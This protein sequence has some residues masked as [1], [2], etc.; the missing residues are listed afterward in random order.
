MRSSFGAIPRSAANITVRLWS[1]T[2]SAVTTPTADSAP[3]DDGRK[4][5]GMRSACASA[6]ACRPPAPPKGTSVKSRGSFPFSTETWR[7]AR[8]IFVLTTSSTPSAA[9][10]ALIFL[11]AAVLI[12][13]ASWVNAVCD[14]AWSSLNSPPSK[15]A[16]GKWPSTTCA[17]V[18]VGSNDRP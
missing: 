15:V 7:S 3:G 16:S 11:R 4:T 18:T 12:S 5:C 1:L 10:I 2:T 14:R 9:S 17:S 8:S 13:E 6:T